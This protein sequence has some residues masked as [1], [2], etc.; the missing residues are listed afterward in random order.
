MR[1]DLISRSSLSKVIE[2]LIVFPEDTLDEEHILMYYA[3]DFRKAV[4]KSINEQ[5][6]AY[7]LEKVIENIKQKSQDIALIYATDKGVDY[8]YADGLTV[9]S[10]IDI[11]KAG[12]IV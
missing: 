7:D 4:L 11:V 3:R 6:V 12:G 9:D 8:E 5:P 2:E 10:A 1:N